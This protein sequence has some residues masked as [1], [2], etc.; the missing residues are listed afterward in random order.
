MA[1]V[2]QSASRESLSRPRPGSTPTSTTPEHPTS[3]AWPSDLF[4]VLSLLEREHA[5]RRA[6]AD[7]ATPA[8]SRTGLAD[9]LLSGK[10]GRPALDLVSD[11]VSSR[12]SRNVRP[13]RGAGV[14]GPQRR[15][16]RGGEGRLARPRRGR[17]VPVRPHPRPRARAGPPAVG[18]GNSRRQARRAAA[19]GV[20][21]PE[22]RHRR[23]PRRPPAERG[24]RRATP[25]ARSRPSRRRC[26]SRPCA[27]GAAATSTW[28]PRALRARRGPSRPLRGPRPHPRPDD[29]RAGAAAHRVA[30]PALRQADLPAGELDPDLLGG[31]VVRVGGELIDGS[32]AGRV[33]TARRTLPS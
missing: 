32:V 27:P 1:S 33:A 25:P 18:L 21:R 28:R 24:R 2:L 4:A 12:W 3:R 14:A 20:D 17:A 8:A 19:G 10:V 22:G 29:R 31:L 15:V 5:L 30:D 11:L 16:R 9:R 26:S 7:S 23:R 13:A 6:L